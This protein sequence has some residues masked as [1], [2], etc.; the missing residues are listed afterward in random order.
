MRKSR[1][2]ITD[3]DILDEILS[4]QVLCR[5]AMADEGKAYIIPVNYGYRDNCMYIHSAPEGKKIDLIRNNP[6][7][8]FEVEDGVEITPGDTAC[9]WSTRYRSVVGYGRAEVLEGKADK[10]EGLEI[11]MRQHGAPEMIH[12]DEKN[13]KALV[14]LRIRIESMSGKKSSNWDENKV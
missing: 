5:L 10:Q 11:I 2:E 14:I 12:F 1:L 9:Q 4:K 13:M 6:K 3:R 7:I 8:C